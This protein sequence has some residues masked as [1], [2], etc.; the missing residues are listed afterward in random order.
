MGG[1]WRTVKP[2]VFVATGTVISISSM[3]KIRRKSA[4]AFIRRINEGRMMRRTAVSVYISALMLLF[5]AEGSFAG[6]SFQLRLSVSKDG[7][8]LDLK[9]IS[10]TRIKALPYFRYTA[11]GDP[12]PITQRGPEHRNNLICT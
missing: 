6:E 9:N 4:K 1:I 12:V 3:P 11:G 2:A 7:L 10:T 5:C 8:H